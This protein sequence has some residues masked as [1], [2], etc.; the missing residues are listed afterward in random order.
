MPDHSPGLAHT[1][2]ARFR[3]YLL[4]LALAAFSSPALSADVVYRYVDDNGVAF[5][6]D[7]PGQIP[8][9]YLSRAQALDAV[10]LQPVQQAPDESVPTPAGLSSLARQADQPPPKAEPPAPPFFASWLEKAAGIRV[11]VPTQ[12]QLGV[13]LTALVLAIGAVI[14]IRI[15]DNLIIKLLLKVSIMLVIGGAVYAMYLSGLNERVS[16]TTHE[17]TGQTTTGKEILEGVA[18]KAGQVKDLLDKTALD[19]AR[20]AIEKTK[21]ATVGDVTKTVEQANRANQQLDK[22]L[23]EIES[24][25]GPP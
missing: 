10:T 20:Q 23:R 8:P 15:S 21:A 11:P 25:P 6:T 12:F 3:S 14:V 1:F 7:N 16:Q 24:S 17:Q 4:I 9:Q 5:F 18:G 19:P 22:S 13:G 2:V